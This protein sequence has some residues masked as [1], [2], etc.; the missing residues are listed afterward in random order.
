MMVEELLCLPVNPKEVL[1][2]LWLHLL[3][4]GMDGRMELGLLR[5]AG[6]AIEVL[7]REWGLLKEHVLM[8][9]VMGWVG[10]EL[11]LIMV[12]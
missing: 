12:A 4:K 5:E 2:L 11:R 9:R 1:K 8:M 6:G 3:R 7:G 10:I